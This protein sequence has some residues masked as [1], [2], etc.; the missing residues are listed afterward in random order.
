MLLDN[1]FC[2]SLLYNNSQMTDSLLNRKKSGKT[3]FYE[4]GA[5]PHRVPTSYSYKQST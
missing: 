4:S 1:I 5:G 2:F 3:L